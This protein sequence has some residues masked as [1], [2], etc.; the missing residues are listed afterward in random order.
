MPHPEWV[1]KH[2]IKNTEIRCI[3][4]KY[5]LYNITSVWCPEKK[6]TKKVTLKCVGSITEEYGLI[7]SGMARKGRIPKGESRIKDNKPETS[8]M[9]TFEK[10][11]DHRATRNQL[12]SVFEILLVT[13]LGV[14]CGAEGWQDI[15][16]YGKAKIDY[17]RRYAEFRNGIPT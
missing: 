7:P 6:R 14:I 15:E 8:F 17:L 10:I 11:E 1:L 9:D 16:N 13:F 5:Y 4:E 2:K 12:Y 3:K